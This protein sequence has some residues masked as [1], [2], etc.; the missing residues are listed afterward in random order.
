LYF[1]CIGRPDGLH[2]HHAAGFVFSSQRCIVHTRQVL[3]KHTHASMC[4]YACASL[5]SCYFSFVYMMEREREREREREGNGR[6]HAWSRFF[7]FFSKGSGFFHDGKR[8]RNNIYGTG[9]GI[10]TRRWSRSLTRK[11]DLLAQRILNKA[12]VAKN[13][14]A[15]WTREREII[16][17]YCWVMGSVVKK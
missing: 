8:T 11:L 9:P 16:R 12:C 13:D 3:P 17:R 14:L 7:V 1:V 10:F 4:T 6:V 2:S 15:I 5:S